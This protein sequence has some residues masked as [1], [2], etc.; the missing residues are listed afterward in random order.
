MG[1]EVN[2]FTFFCTGLLKSMHLQEPRA[3]IKGIPGIF[4]PN[5]LFSLDEVNVWLRPAK[6]PFIEQLLPFL[7]SPEECGKLVEA[8]VVGLF[9]LIHRF[10]RF[11]GHKG[12][13][14]GNAF[15]HIPGKC[16]G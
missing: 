10:I 3:P 7:D 15:G 16:C 5:S 12:S 4:V 14:P 9:G 8:C 6:D 1:S 11:T 13:S 2:F